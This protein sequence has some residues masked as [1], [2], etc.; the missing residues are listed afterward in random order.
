MK[1]QGYSRY[2]EQKRW[3]RNQS[4]N[5]RSSLERPIVSFVTA[6]RELGLDQFLTT[7]I[8]KR[9]LAFFLVDLLSGDAAP[10]DEM[11]CGICEPAL[12]A[13]TNYGFGSIAP[14][15]QTM[16]QRGRCWWRLRTPVSVTEVFVK[17]N[18][19]SVWHDS[20]IGR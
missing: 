6:I 3:S 11:P 8:D 1:G 4:Q 14:P 18:S 17:Y 5:H 7:G 19:A 12:L 9:F 2:P 13:L 16:R 20:N 15:S 10:N